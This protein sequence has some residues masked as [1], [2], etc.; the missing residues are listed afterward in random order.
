[1]KSIT[2][3][4]IHGTRGKKT[5]KRVKKE[6]QSAVALGVFV[7]R[8][9]KVALRPSPPSSLFFLSFFRV[10]RVFRGFLS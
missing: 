2:N 5:E 1:V 9:K 3:H 4:G 7:A 6:G 8:K 10:F